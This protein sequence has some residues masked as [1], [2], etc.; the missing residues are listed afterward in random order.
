MAA[1][2]EPTATTRAYFRGTLP[3]PLARRRRRGELGQP[4]PRCRRRP[5]EAHPDDGAAP[6]HQGPRRR[7]VRRRLVTGRARCPA[8]HVAIPVRS[9]ARGS[10]TVAVCLSSSASRSRRPKEHV[11]ETDEVAVPTERGEKLKGELDDLLDEIDEVLEEN[12]EDFVNHMCR[13]GV[14][15]LMSDSCRSDVSCHTPVRSCSDEAMHEVRR[16]KPL[17]DSTR[18]GHARWATRR[19]QGVHSRHGRRGTREP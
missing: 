7:A 1:T 10:G 9:P 2:T 8:G 11:E 17:D 14:S 5:A 18:E 15:D 19:L 3:R 4:H 16:V 6:G 12:A 13:K